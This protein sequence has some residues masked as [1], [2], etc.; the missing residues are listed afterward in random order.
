MIEPSARRC[1]E[2]HG[3]TSRTGRLLESRQSEV[4]K[5]HVYDDHEDEAPRGVLVASRRTNAMRPAALKAAQVRDES[6]YDE[7]LERQAQHTDPAV[8]RRAEAV[9]AKRAKAAQ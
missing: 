3:F 6:E 1:A 4:T 5:A 9:I 7:Y 2:P 8:R